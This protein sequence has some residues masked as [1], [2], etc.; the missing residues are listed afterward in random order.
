MNDILEEVKAKN[1]DKTQKEWWK[2]ENKRIRQ[3]TGELKEELNP[4]WIK[5]QRVKFLDDCLRH[6]KILMKFWEFWWEDSKEM[7]M[8]NWWRE[9]IWRGWRVNKL[10]KRIRGIEYQKKAMLAVE[11][12]KGKVSQEDIERAKEIPFSEFLEFKK[13]KALCP[14]HNEK[15]PSFHW[16]EGNR[17][18]HCFGCGK[19]LDIIQ[20]IMETQN[21]SFP[22]A[23]KFLLKEE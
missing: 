20:Y 4:K 9:G 14:F 6:N 15:T 18:A 10:E 7:G 23:V 11:G 8:P 3:E 2:V 1:W 19:H 13:G 21:M 22:D 12:K 17:F 5:Q 16:T